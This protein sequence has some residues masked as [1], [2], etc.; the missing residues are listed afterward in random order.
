ML[1]YIEIDPEIL[2]Q[3]QA[4]LK[5]VILGLIAV[6]GTASAVGIAFLRVRIVAYINGKT[7]KAKAEGKSAE[8]IA[9]LEAFKCVVAKLDSWSTAAVA[10]VEQ[11]LVRQLKKEEGQWNVQ[12]ARQ[13]RD[14]AVDVMKRLAGDQGI[15]ELETCTGKTKEAIFTMFRTWVELKVSGSGGEAANSPV[16]PMDDADIAA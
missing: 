1:T 9:H 11:T 2:A 12:T 10:E 15:A 16:V 13:A 5:T 14:T 3:G 4:L 7:E 8:A 6:L